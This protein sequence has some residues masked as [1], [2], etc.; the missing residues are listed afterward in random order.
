VAN[1]DRY[2]TFTGPYLWPW[3]G[4][5]LAELRARGR[6]VS[7]LRGLLWHLEVILWQTL[8]SNLLHM[9]RVSRDLF[10]C[11]HADGGISGS[12]EAMWRLKPR[13]RLRSRP[14]WVL[15][16]AMAP[17]RDAGGGCVSSPRPSNHPMFGCCSWDW[18]G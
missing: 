15:E 17:A 12:G 10:G 16:M 11:V 3:E 13:S 8:R 9:R 18:K 4:R 14:G 7:R 6:R 2:F 5:W 1:G